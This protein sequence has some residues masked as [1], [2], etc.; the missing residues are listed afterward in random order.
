MC[1][2]TISS[3]IRKEGLGDFYQLYLNYGH[4]LE[5]HA[6]G[7]ASLSLMLLDA[8]GIRDL[9]IR[10][11]VIITSLFHDI[12]ETQLPHKIF[13][14]PTLTDKDKELLNKHPVIGAR[15]LG[16][17]VSPHVKDMILSHHM[18][19]NGDGYGIGIPDRYT[20]IVR[21]ADIYSALVSPRVYRRAYTTEEVISTMNRMA[22]R[23]HINSEIWAVLKKYLLN[24]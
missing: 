18:D 13:I 6:I 17:E 5:K 8:L 19:S 15:L 9:N 20:E 16:D 11:D 1:Y 2:D 23:G 3:I 14:T 12:G 7:C 4:D 22:N 21:V 10:R 24:I